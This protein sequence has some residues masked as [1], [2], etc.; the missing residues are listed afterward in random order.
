MGIM[1]SVS[2]MKKCLVCRI[3]AY[4]DCIIITP[5]I[6]KLKELG[7]YVVVHTGKRG[8]EALKHNPYIDEFSKHDES[9][10]IA[11]FLD[12]IKKVRKEQNPDKFIDF[13]E[14][15]EVNVALHPIGPRYVYPK[16]E[17][18]KFCNK[19]YYDVTEE[20]ANLDGT[21]CQK[22]PDLHFSKEEEEQVKKIIQP[23]KFNIL[24]ALSGSGK[25]KV[26]PWTEFVIGEVLKNLKNVHVI[27]VGDERCQ[28][29]E[30]L[31]VREVTNLSGKLPMRFSMCLTKFTD[32]VISPD[33]GVLHASGAFDTPKIGLLGHTTI[34][35]ITKYF[36]ND[37]SLEAKCACAP[38]FYLIY[39]YKIQCPV[40]PITKA[41][42]CMAHGITPER[43]YGQIIEVYRNWQKK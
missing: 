7:Y 13:S 10:P 5:V 14:S 3:G 29:L 17:R 32:L 20:W 4:G 30:T 2:S 12:N 24:W 40:D 9:V 25:Q 16:E 39:D 11:Q 38:C 6:K 28:L 42:W 33:T 36:E 22:L 23:N 19:N 18:K 1:E 8:L 21:P 27:T 15:I 43:V 34:E 26:Y 31:N 35:N 41:A 37:Y